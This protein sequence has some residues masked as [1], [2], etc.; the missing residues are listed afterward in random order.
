[1]EGEGKFGRQP[2]SVTAVE[3]LRV[4]GLQAPSLC[5]PG[6]RFPIPPQSP[7]KLPGEFIYLHYGT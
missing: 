1:M 7:L 5:N 4:W 3:V 6:L 2:S